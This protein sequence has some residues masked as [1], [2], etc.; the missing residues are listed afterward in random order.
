VELACE[1]SQT[2]HMKCLAL[3]YNGVVHGYLPQTPDASQ[4]V[5]AE[6]VQDVISRYSASLHEIG[7]EWRSHHLPLPVP[8]GVEARW[9]DVLT[10]EFSIP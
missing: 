7:G 3:C 6:Q 1:L 4:Q 5:A 2:Y 10:S 9:L 8:Q